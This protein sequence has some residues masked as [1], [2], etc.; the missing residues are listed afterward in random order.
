MKPDRPRIIKLPPDGWK[1]QTYYWVRVQMSEF[2]TP[3][4]A[5][6]Y[7]G[8]L[9]GENNTP[10]AYAGRLAGADQYFTDYRE[11]YSI[12]FVAEISKPNET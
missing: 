12:E 7:S 4:F 2:N 9:N 6:F 8:F 11:L 1:P 3:H 5:I 10:G